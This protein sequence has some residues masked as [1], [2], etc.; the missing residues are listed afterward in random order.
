MILGVNSC[1]FT[2]RESLSHSSIAFSQQ[3]WSQIRG[4]RLVDAHVLAHLTL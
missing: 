1:V 3:A 2:L 4:G